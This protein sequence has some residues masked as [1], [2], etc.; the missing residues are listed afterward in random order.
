MP[1]Q[2]MSL[3]CASN[4]S[5]TLK[6][7]LDLPFRSNDDIPIPR[8]NSDTQ[9]VNERGKKLLQL[10]KNT[11]IRILNGRFFG[12]TMGRFTCYSNTGKPSTI[13]YMLSSS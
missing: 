6:E 8:L 13:D 10:C 1:E 2:I 11:D 9:R 5:D 12:D 3:N 4:T 7:H